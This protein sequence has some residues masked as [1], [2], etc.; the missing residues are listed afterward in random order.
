MTGKTL[1]L[2]KDLA[3]EDTIAKATSLLTRMG[4]ATEAVSWL[5]P[6]P[7]C[8]SVH[9]EAS[10]CPHLYTNGKGTSRL[11]ALAS[12]LGEFFERL[13]T[14]LF[15]ADFYL[16]EKSDDSHF[17]FYPGEVWFP[18]GK[19]GTVPSARRQGV[20]L[21][22]K[23]LRAFYNP[24]GELTA[25]HLHD[26]NID[27]GDGALCALPFQ[28]LATG[29]TTYFPI[30]LLNNLYVS[31]GMAAGNS[32]AECTSQALSEIIERYVK[33]IVIGQGISL[34][35]VPSAQLQKYPH[36]CAI[37]DA[38]AER[39]LSVR[40]KDASLGGRFPVISVLVADPDSGGVF[41]AFGANCRLA[42][43]VERTLTELLQGRNL[44]QFNNFQRPCHDLQQV[45]DPFNLE[46]HFV[47]SD[48]LLSWNMLQ[49][50]ANFAFTPWD[51]VGSTNQEMQR[52]QRIIASEGFQMYRAEYLHCG[53]YS[54][55]ILV[56]GMS[57]IYPLDD[58]LYNNKGTGAVLRPYLLR[59]AQMHGPELAQ[60]LRM[61]ESLD[62]H[63]EQL[64][65]QTIGVLFAEHSAWATLRIG[66]LKAM[67]LL[68]FGDKEAA[69]A[70]CSWCVDYGALPAGR[71]RLYRLL[72][73]LLSFFLNGQDI[74]GFSTSLQ[75]FYQEDELH[76]AARIIDG[77]ITFFGLDFAGSW[78]EIS[79]E[80]QKML[81]IYSTMHH[82]KTGF[83]ESKI[84]A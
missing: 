56:P 46:S 70:W 30:S 34:P 71:I 1:P 82:I 68:A 57:E 20:E 55:R 40:V 12:G 75:L 25:A 11:A 24:Q 27:G 77:S 35:D 29:Q 69:L 21:L 64:I 5:N 78:S 66:E 14:N 58:L 32:A 84:P 52:L 62:L 44:D 19:S 60:L 73:T 26:N 38:L 54:C 8:W 42:T 28:S 41:A 83:T 2:G 37:L 74:A 9:I 53:M 16:G 63:D 36:L 6:A 72:Q 18:P 79:I 45:A 33:N 76:Q 61:L 23:D 3:L 7:N 67:I 49:D 15:F 10:A 81:D 48:G 59:L 17:H 43:A 13:A 47:D 65:G 51:F 31:N 39:K 50:K 80:H 22:N 4:I